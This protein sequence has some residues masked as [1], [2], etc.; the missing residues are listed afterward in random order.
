MLAAVL[1][2]LAVLPHESNARCASS[3]IVHLVGTRMGPFG[4]IR[5]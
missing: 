2:V 5:G 3:M 4:D 1:G